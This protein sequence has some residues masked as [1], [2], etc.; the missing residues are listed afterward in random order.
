MASHHSNGSG[1]GPCYVY[2][3]MAVFFSLRVASL[4]LFSTT[5]HLSDLRLCLCMPTI[6]HRYSKSSFLTFVSARM[7]AFHDD[8][9]ASTCPPA[10]TTPL[11]AFPTTRHLFSQPT[12][13]K[14]ILENAFPCSFMHNSS[15]QYAHHSYKNACLSPLL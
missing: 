2:A 12:S 7:A 3:T 9:T 1:S 15:L 6:V 13:D 4:H 14:T 10:Y 5:R 8:F 11:T